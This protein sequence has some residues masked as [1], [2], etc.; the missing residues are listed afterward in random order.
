MRLVSTTTF[1]ASVLFVP[2]MFAEP[3]SAFV[4]HW[5]VNAAKSRSDQPIGNTVLKIR[6]VHNGFEIILQHIRPGGN[7]PPRIFPC[8]LDGKE[9]AFTLP[10]AK[11]SSHTAT[12]KLIDARTMERIVNHDNGKMITT[13]RTAVSTDGRTLQEVWTGK[14]EDG[15]PI[16]LLYVFDRE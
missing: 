13:S 1:F 10:D 5:K 8:V 3:A 14:T 12:C 16:D 15:K 4:G 7:P 6:S 9:H 11:H 2:W